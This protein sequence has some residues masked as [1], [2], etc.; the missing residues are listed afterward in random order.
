[1]KTEIINIGNSVFCDGCNGD[2][3]DSDAVGGLLYGTNA[4][5]PA[6]AISVEHNA[7]EFNETQFIRGRAR[8]G[9][10][11][12]AFVYELRCGQDGIVTVTLLDGPPDN[13]T[14]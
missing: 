11:F 1:V 6:C 7:M 5:C 12:R 9:Q 8:K 4:Y 2:Y 14:A 3:T 10:E 13:S